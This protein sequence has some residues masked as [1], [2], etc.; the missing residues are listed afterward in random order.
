MQI[1][2]RDDL[3]EVDWRALKAAL[4]AD[5]FD[6][7]RTPQ[8]L[9]RSFQNSHAAC[10]AWHEG[11]LVGTARV[12]SDGVCNAYLVDVWTTS[13]LRRQ[14]IAREMVQRLL[15][16]LPGQHIYLQADDDLVEF[17]R[18]LGFAEQPTGMNRVVGKWL[19]NDPG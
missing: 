9:Q 7:G 17:Y 11:E 19:V 6:N 1:L 2:Y 3:H 13:R 15:R 18:R 10:I 16:G 5:N 4:A 8:Q 12:L 14:G